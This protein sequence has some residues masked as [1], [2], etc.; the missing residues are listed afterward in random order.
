LTAPNGP[1]GDAPAAPP[2]TAADGATA[3][4][5]A[6]SRAQRQPQP[7]VQQSIPPVSNPAFEPTYAAVNYAEVGH[8]LPPRAPQYDTIE[9]VRDQYAELGPHSTYNSADTEA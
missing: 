6:L 8:V 9:F 5:S 1:N 2:P 4:A 3:S 7:A